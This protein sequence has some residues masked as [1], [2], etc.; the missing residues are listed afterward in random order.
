MTHY[1]RGYVVVEVSLAALRRLTGDNRHPAGRAVRS[2]LVLRFGAGEAME[3]SVET[4][5]GAG[6]RFRDPG[7][8]VWSLGR[9]GWLTRHDADGAT[10]FA[11]DGVSLAAVRFR[12]ALRAEAAQL[13]ADLDRG[14]IR[15]WILSGDRQTNVD[16]QAAIRNIP[17]EHAL[18]DLRPE[19]K[20]EQVVRLEADACTLMIGDGA[21]DSLAFD[22]ASCR[23]TPVLEQTMPQ[24]PGLALVCGCIPRGIGLWVRLPRDSGDESILNIIKRRSL[25]ADGVNTL[26]AAPSNG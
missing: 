19:A 24:R 26:Q 8:S 2:E 1:I 10:V 17:R 14:N 9:A 11:R 18:R 13:V 3:G 23:G 4:V 22:A 5:P 15:T 25:E 12:E 21:N 16:R 20:A 7:G 6:C